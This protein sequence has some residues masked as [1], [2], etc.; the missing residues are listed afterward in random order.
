MLGG[1]FFWFS[2]T[3]YFIWYMLTD[4]E[5]YEPI[6]QCRE[7]YINNKYLHELEQG[8]HDSNISM[9]AMWMNID[10]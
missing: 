2:I 10:E 4:T 8:Q 3:L 1:G 7:S 5:T 6:G 9:A